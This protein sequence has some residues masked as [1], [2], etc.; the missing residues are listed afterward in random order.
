MARLAGLDVR[1]LDLLASEHTRLAL[2]L[3]AN[4]V[5]LVLDIGANTGQWA[6]ELRRAGYAGDMISFEPLVQAHTQLRKNAL[7]DP[8]WVVAER[9]ALGERIADV[10]IHIA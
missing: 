1:R 6:Q 3:A 9:M 10:E 5:D 8:R 2:L 4:Q 7:G